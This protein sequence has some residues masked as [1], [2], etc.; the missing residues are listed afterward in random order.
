MK[1]SFADDRIVERIICAIIPTSHP[2]WL[3]LLIKEY[4]DDHDMDDDL[5]SFSKIIALNNAGKFAKWMKNRGFTV[6][7]YYENRNSDNVLDWSWGIEIADSCP[8]LMEYRLK[9]S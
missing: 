1:I 9:V 4:M 3:V 7:F 6:E 8:T 5:M 2:D